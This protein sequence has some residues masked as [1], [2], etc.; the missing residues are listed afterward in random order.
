MFYDPWL[1]VFVVLSSLHPYRL[2]LSSRKKS[3]LD[4]WSPFL[5]LFPSAPATL[6][7][8]DHGQTRGVE[9]KDDDQVED[10]GEQRQFNRKHIKIFYIIEEK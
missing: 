2:V 9:C 8:D 3:L 6:R 1:G 4:L 10:T 5:L 7:L